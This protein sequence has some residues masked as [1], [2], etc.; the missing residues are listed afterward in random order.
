LH[1]ENGIPIESWFFNQTD[2]ELLKLSSLLE[3]LSKVEDVRH[4]I[5][6]F[7]IKDE[8]SFRI[9]ELILDPNHK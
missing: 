3:N 5:S 4:Y 6:K 9:A 2:A 1:P 8:I 7:V